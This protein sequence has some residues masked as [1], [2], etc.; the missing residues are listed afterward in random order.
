MIFYQ[1]SIA[2]LGFTMVFPVLP[3]PIHPD[4]PLKDQSFGAL[5]SFSRHALRRLPDGSRLYNLC[6][7]QLRMDIGYSTDL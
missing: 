6:G 4:S 3:D 1:S 7:E 2:S 5:R